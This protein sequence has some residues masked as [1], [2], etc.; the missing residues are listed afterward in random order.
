MKSAKFLQKTQPN[1]SE[2]LFF[3]WIS[4]K[5]G[6]INRLNQSETDQNLNQD[7]LMFIPASKTAPSLQIPGY[8]CK[9]LPI[10]ASLRPGNTAP[11]EGMSQR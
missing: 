2:D 10:S 4:P 5:F 9:F 11:F 3:A 8:A 6:Q 1:L 7:R